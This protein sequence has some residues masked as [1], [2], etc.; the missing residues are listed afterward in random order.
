MLLCDITVDED[1]C[2]ASE[3]T[4]GLNCTTCAPT[5]ANWSCNDRGCPVCPPVA[6]GG[7]MGRVPG[8]FLEDVPE[9]GVEATLALGENEFGTASPVVCAACKCVPLMDSSSTWFSCKKAESSDPTSNCRALEGT[10]Q[11]RSPCS[12]STCSNRIP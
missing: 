1:D 10:H 5:M 6:E 8:P 9:T 2:F 12:H 3:V 4:A 11:C 7:E